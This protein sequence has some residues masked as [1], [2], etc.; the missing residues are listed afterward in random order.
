MGRVLATY[1]V[2]PSTTD[3][4]LKA[5]AQQV[6]QSMPAEAVLRGIQIEDIAYGL[7]A[8]LL[9]VE[10]PDAGGIQDTIERNLQGLPHV[11]TVEVLDADLI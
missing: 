8:L 9:A 2:T 6:R 3:A 4:D 5:L 10:M 11:E 7:R 1:R